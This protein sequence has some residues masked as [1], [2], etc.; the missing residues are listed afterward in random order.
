MSTS[1]DDRGT[2][3]DEPSGRGISRR[4]LLR[5]G[6]TV[7]TALVWAAPVVQTINMRAARAQVGSPPPPTDIES[8]FLILDEEAIDNGSPPNFFGASDVNDALASPSQRS[9]LAFFNDPGNFDTE[10]DLYSGE[11]GGEGWFALETI[12]ASWGAN[13]LEDFIAGTLSQSVLA[14]VPDVTPLRAEGLLGLVGLTVAVLVHDS[15]ISMNYGPING[16]L[17][18]DY[19]G[20]AA[21]EV[22]SVAQFVGGSSSTLPV[23][24]I[25]IVNP[26]TVFA[27]TILLYNAP[28][29]TDSSTPFDVVP[30]GPG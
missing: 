14:G 23:V 29:I 7:G 5:R 20:L 18:G 15:D 1:E 9:F 19:L 17:Q 30:G 3:S 2:S 21:F 12:P 4:Q 24:H 28:T 13:G 27:G 16:S 6:A 11:V 22:L 10:I 25:K 8:V 26:A